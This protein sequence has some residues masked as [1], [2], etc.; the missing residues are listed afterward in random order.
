[1]IDGNSFDGFD[2]G[3]STSSAYNGGL[4]VGGVSSPLWWQQSNGNINSNTF[5]I[6]AVVVVAGVLVWKWKK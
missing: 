6:A 4:T 1:M 5:L 2:V 3:D